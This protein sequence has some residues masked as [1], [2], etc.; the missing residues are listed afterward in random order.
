MYPSINSNN[1]FNA[2]FNVDEGYIS[3]DILS[4]NEINFTEKYDANKLIF[5]LNNLDEIGK[6]FRPDARNKVSLEKYCP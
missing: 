2:L 1:L 6:L 4:L 5:I 3:S